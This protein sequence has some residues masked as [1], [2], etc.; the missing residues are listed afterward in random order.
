V[1]FVVQEVEVEQGIL[2]AASVF[3]C[4]KHYGVIGKQWSLR[5]FFASR[6]AD[7]FISRSAEKGDTHQHGVNK[8]SIK[9][10]SI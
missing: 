9:G 8:H 10:F 1:K 7:V 2:Q 3:P 5:D 6:S 4:T